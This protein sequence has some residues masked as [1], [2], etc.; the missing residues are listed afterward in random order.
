MPLIVS[1]VTE[2]STASGDPE[3]AA[4]VAAATGGVVVTSDHLQPLIDRLG[5]VSRETIVRAGH[6]FR[7]PWWGV[8]FAGLLSAEWAMR[9]RRGLR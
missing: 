9:R 6:P 7:S 5:A 4:T 2:P 1:P 8:A 3:I